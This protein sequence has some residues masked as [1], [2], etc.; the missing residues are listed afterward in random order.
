MPGHPVE[1]AGRNY[2]RGPRG[3]PRG[4]GFLRA[5]TFLMANRLDRLA[6]SMGD[7]QDIFALAGWGGAA[8]RQITN[9]RR[10]AS[11]E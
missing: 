2:D 7:L 10:I 8:S 5:G 4:L 1:E 3:A 9:S 6:R 11:T